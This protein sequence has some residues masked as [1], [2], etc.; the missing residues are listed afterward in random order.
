MRTILLAVLA[1]GLA[2]LLAGCATPAYSGGPATLQPMPQ[3]ATGE[4]MNRIVRNWDYDAKMITD[5]LTSIW[6]LDPSSLLTTWSVR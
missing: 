4:Q 5:D 3:K 2:G 1:L 6:M